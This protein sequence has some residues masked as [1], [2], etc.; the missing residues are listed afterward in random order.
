MR[1]PLRLDARIGD[2]AALGELVAHKADHRVSVCLPAR[3]EAAT[4]GTIVAEIRR[5]LV[6]EVGLVDELL[7]IDDHSA[8]DTAAVA[9]RAGARVIDA[10]T[11]LAEHTTGPGKGQA[12]WKSLHQSTGDLIVWCDADIERFDVRL[13][14]GQIAALLLHP[15]IAFVKGA[16]ARP[17]GGGDVGGR[18]TELLAR[19]VLATLFPE[20]AAISQPLSGEYG[21]RRW[22]LETLPFVDGY[23]VD[24]ALLLDAIA[25]VGIEG[26][27]E[28]DLGT[29]HHRNRPLDELG[30]QAT[31]VLRAA[32][33]RA[34]IDS[35]D[36]PVALRRPQREPLL[37]A[38]RE[39]P[40]LVELT[41]YRRRTA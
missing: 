36:H 35:G 1:A 27:A 39:L 22:L 20:A 3:D 34:G 11:T 32:L 4:V 16:Y 30:P 12:L 7:V 19:P 2:P 10:A 21:G 41:D 38:H 17:A 18:V 6:D 37:V 8:D 28:V 15:E 23:G 24:I 9:R 40:P 33:T 29:R 31:A 14:T 5:S 25:A 13:V 26:I